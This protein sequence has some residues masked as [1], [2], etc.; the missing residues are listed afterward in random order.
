MVSRQ[1]AYDL[2]VIM[3]IWAIPDIHGRFDLLSVLLETTPINWKE[4]QVVFL[5]DMIDR[6]PQ[7]KEVV[8]KIMELQV[9]YP[10][11]VTVLL[12]NHEDMMLNAVRGKDYDD[13]MFWHMN[14][15]KETK[16][17]WDPDP[18]PEDVL[19]WISNLPYV[20]ELPGFIFSHSPIPRETW[21]KREVA[22]TPLTKDE[23]LWTRSRDEFGVARDHGSGCVGVCGHNHALIKGVL[24]P[25]FYPH[26]IY[27]DTGSG[28]DSRAPLVAI[29]V[30]SRKV[31]YAH[32][33][34]D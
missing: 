30:K 4:D 13:I 21:R 28:C 2:G 5:G 22:G 15:G 11:N 34:K 31:Y 18:I 17:S 33:E 19:E 27:A 23:Y 9:Q 29:E 20:F 32:P 1:P 3:N 8:E 12:G 10:D 16:L 24:K 25:R 6:G 7:S 14:G 26:Y